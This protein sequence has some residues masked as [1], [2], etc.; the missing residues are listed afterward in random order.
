M[1]LNALVIGVFIALLVAFGIV[2]SRA[3]RH[4]QRNRLIA[5]SLDT[6]RNAVELNRAKGVNAPELSLTPAF[7]KLRVLASSTSPEVLDTLKA[8][9][10]RCIEIERR[11][12]EF[13]AQDTVSTLQSSL[14]TGRTEKLV[15]EVHELAQ[16]IEQQLGHRPRQA[17]KD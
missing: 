7:E 1:E 10:D 13:K 8:M 5:R 3:T 2:A 4:H 15:S 12:D 9:E 6:I 17:G 11:I 16:Q 14:T